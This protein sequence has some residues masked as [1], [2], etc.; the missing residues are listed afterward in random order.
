[1]TTDEV[2]AFCLLTNRK[3]THELLSQK[4]KSN[5]YYKIH[6]LIGTIKLII[7]SDEMVGLRDKTT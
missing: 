4:S 2:N 3:N 1:M 5:Y 7:K 6:V